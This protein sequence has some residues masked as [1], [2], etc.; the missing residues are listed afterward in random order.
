[1]CNSKDI[2]YFTSVQKLSN[3]LKSIA[4]QPKQ[5]HTTKWRALPFIQGTEYTVLFMQTLGNIINIMYLLQ[6]ACWK[7]QHSEQWK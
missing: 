6:R 2:Q 1:M 3:F 5:C 7:I 4:E